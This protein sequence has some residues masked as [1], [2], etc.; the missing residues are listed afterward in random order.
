MKTSIVLIAV[1]AFGLLAGCAATYTPLVDYKS[2]GKTAEQYQADLGECRQYAGEVAGPGTGAAA[3]AVAGAAVGLLLS[4]LVGGQ[5]NGSN[6]RLGAGMGALGGASGGG[7]SEVA[8][9]RKCMQGR[10]YSVLN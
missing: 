8:V 9:I 5:N 1:S 4:H 2:G 3:G 10:G 6:A 7:Q